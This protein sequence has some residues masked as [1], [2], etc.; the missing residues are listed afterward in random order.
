MHSS[1]LFSNIACSLPV[2]SANLRHS[3][4]VLH[5]GDASGAAGCVSE[6]TQ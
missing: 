2:F 4:T 1:S 5:A 6:Q 3:S